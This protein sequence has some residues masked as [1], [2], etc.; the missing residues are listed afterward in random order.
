MVS[1]FIKDGQPGIYSSLFG[2]SPV[3]SVCVCVCVR[4][5]TRAHMYVCMYVYMYRVPPLTYR[6]T[7]S[8]HKDKKGSF[9]TRHTGNVP[10][11]KIKWDKNGFCWE[12]ADLLAL[13]CDVR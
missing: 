5:C 13:V 7:S 3:K 9:T 6:R 2:G 4:A 10:G 11:Y 8:S 12:R 1:Y